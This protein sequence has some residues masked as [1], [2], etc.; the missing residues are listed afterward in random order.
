MPAFC[1]L[2]AFSGSRKKS[3]KGKQYVCQKYGEKPSGSKL[4]N[5]VQGYCRARKHLKVAW[6]GQRA[7]GVTIQIQGFSLRRQGQSVCRLRRHR[8]HGDRHLRRR[9][10]D[11]RAARRDHGRSERPGYPPSRR[12]PAAIR[13][14]REPRQPGAGAAG[15]A[16]RRGAERPNQENEGNPGGRAAEARRDRRTRCRQGGRRGAHREHEE[17]RRGDQEP[18]LGRA[19]AA[20]TGRPARKALRRGAQGAAAF[21]GRCRTSGHR[22]A[23]RALQHLRGPQLLAS[24]SHPGTQDRR[25]AR[26]HRRQRQSHGVRHDRRA[27]D[28]QQRSTR[29]D[30]Q[31]LPHRAGAREVESRSAAQDHGDAVRSKHN[32]EPAGA[33]RRQDRRLQGPPAG[34]GCG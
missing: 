10:P 1:F 33:C 4:V 5:R 30:R 31:G 3:T 18:R 9:R 22:R 25:P 11:A 26:R 14:E 15:C 17:H 2:S 21:R 19:R 28:Q 34:T 7:N 32:L 23:D 20:R 8:R 13:T 24:R 12:Q 16:Q 6:T 27:F 29:S